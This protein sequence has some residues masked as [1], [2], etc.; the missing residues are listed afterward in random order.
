MKTW[1]TYLKEQKMSKRFLETLKG[2]KTDR[3]PFWFMRQAGRYL[4]E[5]L[6]TRADAG[7]FLDLVYNPELAVEVTLQP[8]RRYHP[9]VVFLLGRKPQPQNH[10]P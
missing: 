2:N 3:P 5:Y 10:N 8:I 7:S 1:I 4:P 6:K 9:V